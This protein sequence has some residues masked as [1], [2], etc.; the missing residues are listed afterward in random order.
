VG[1]R[2]LLI[3]LFMTGTAFLEVIQGLGFAKYG[4]PFRLDLRYRYA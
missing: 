3:P 2:N 4:P 1:Q